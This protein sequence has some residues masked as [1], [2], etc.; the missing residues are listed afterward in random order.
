MSDQSEKMCENSVQPVKS[1]DHEALNRE[2]NDNELELV[3]G[4]ALSPEQVA[5]VKKL[6]EESGKHHG[7]NVAATIAAYTIGT[8]GDFFAN[9]LGQHAGRQVNKNNSNQKNN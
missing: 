6:A 3:L 9:T 2:L 1:G 5:E 7:V 4:G 8:F